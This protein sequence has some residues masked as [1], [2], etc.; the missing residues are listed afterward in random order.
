MALELAEKGYRDVHALQ[1]GFDAWAEAG[2]PLEPRARS[3][4]ETVG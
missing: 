4:R 2:L 3:R 1:G